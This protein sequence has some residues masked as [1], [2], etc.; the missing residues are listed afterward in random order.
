MQSRGGTQAGPGALAQNKTSESSW[1]CSK[2]SPPEANSPNLNQIKAWGRC[3]YDN[4]FQKL[5]N[6]PGAHPT[7]NQSTRAAG[8]ALSS[9]S[10]LPCQR[11]W[12]FCRGTPW[13][14]AECFQA[15]KLS[16]KATRPSDYLR[17]LETALGKA[18]ELRPLS[19]GGLVQ[20][21]DVPRE[22]APPFPGP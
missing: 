4:S 21:L 19:S 5:H 18:L 16:R 10:S 13:V 7:P 22:A 12:G 2:P 8:L 6:K 9:Q 11:K 20:A 17:N 14:G 15:I 1:G 3:S